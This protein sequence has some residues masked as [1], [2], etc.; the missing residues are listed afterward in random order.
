MLVPLLSAAQL[1]H[2]GRDALRA[3]VVAERA[4]ERGAA[5]E[6]LAAERAREGAVVVEVDVVDCREIAARVE[7]DQIVE[8]RQ[9]VLADRVRELLGEHP[10]RAPGKTR[11]RLLMSSGVFR[12]RLWNA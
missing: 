11:F 3:R 9:P 12:V 4:G 2:D 8:P 10:V 5:E 6:D 7:V 1:A